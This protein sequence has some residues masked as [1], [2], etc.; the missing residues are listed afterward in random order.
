MILVEFE[1]LD[2]LRFVTFRLKQE[3]LDVLAPYA[4]V[5][6]GSILAQGEACHR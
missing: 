5:C 3:L 4:V 1:G 6:T 2:F